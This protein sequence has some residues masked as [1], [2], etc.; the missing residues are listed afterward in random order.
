MRYPFLAGAAVVVMTAALAACG[1]SADG[2]GSKAAGAHSPAASGPAVTG[3]SA[4]GPSAESPAEPG[5]GA[6]TGAGT[7]P[8]SE[9]PK[10]PADRITPATGSFTEEQKGYLV[11]R[12]PQGM[13]PAAVLQNGQE[14]C[15]RIGYLVKADREIAVGAIVTGEIPEAKPAIAHLCT[16]HRE[17][18][19]EAARGYPDGTH[20][21]KTLRPGRYHSVSPTGSCSWQIAGVGGKGLGSGTS[22]SGKRVEITLPKTA[23]TFTS[24]GCYAWLPEGETG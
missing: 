12:V 8:T 24:T 9:G 17:L 21:G 10:V 5:S 15:D 6:D 22:G 13:D 1:S 3:P 16:Q 18:V 23:R 7:G 14:T 20:S 2:N 11:N 19:K 4:A